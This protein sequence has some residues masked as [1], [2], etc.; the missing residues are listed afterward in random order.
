MPDYSKKLSDLVVKAKEIIWDYEECGIDNLLDIKVMKYIDG[1]Y[2]DKTK[3][4]NKKNTK[5][6]EIAEIVKLVFYQLPKPNENIFKNNLTYSDDSKKSLKIDYLCLISICNIIWYILKD[7]VDQKNFPQLLNEIL[8]QNNYSKIMDVKI[9]DASLMKYKN[10]FNKVESISFN[11]SGSHDANIELYYSILFY[12]FYKVLFPNVHH[13][14][15]NL[16]ETKINN[17]YNADKNPYKIRENDVISFCD[18]FKYLFLSNFIITSLIGS[19]V[20][21]QSLRIVMYESYIHEIIHVFSNEFEKS[22]FREKIS[23]KHSLIYFRKLMLISQISRLSITINCLDRILFKEIINLIVLNRNTEILELQLFPDQKPYNLRKLYLNYLR[24]LEFDEIDPEINEKYQIIMYPYVDSLDN[25]SPLIE[26]EKIPDLLFPIFKKNINNLRLA[27]NDYIKAYKSFYL[28]I[29]P[30]EELCKYDNYNVEILLFIY[31]ILS[32]L[33]TSSMIN[34]LQIQCLNINYISVQQIKKTIN[35]LKKEKLKEENKNVEL[36]DIDLSKCEVLESIIFNMT[37]ISFFVDFSKLPISSLK[38]LEIEISSL[39]DLKSINEGLRNQKDKFKKLTEIRLN[40]CINNF[41]DIFDEL[42]KI[43]EN[44]PFSVEILKIT[45]E[46]IIGKS[47]LYKILKAY[48]RNIRKEQKI[49]CSLYCNS[50][51]L[52]GFSDESKIKLLKDS[53]NAE[54]GLFINKCELISLKP[55]NQAPIVKRIIFSLV[56]WP[57]KNIM[58]SIINSFTKNANEY[59]DFQRYNKNIFSRIFSFIGNTHELVLHL[60]QK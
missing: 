54:N 25:I 37:G 28:D 32:A 45:I 9:W 15:I 24:G 21:L 53:F 3:N 20:N 40:I 2:G 33:E 59:K 17:I 8:E 23:I 52:E 41:E 48:H 30:Y 6:T 58:E 49:N 4:Q 26:E 47:E 1:L 36:K 43:F 46:N 19:N 31:I 60:D 14:Y 16:N 11:L 57:E 42:L 27:L 56:D 22:R 44:I 38:S 7:I 13:I 5:G 50:K 55:K 12:Y 29:S 18:K 34:K 39:K 35:K 51:E 10:D